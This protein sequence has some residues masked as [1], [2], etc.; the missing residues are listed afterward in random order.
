VR[1]PPGFVGKRKQFVGKRKQ[2]V[3]KGKGKQNQIE[4]NFLIYWN[5]YS[6]GEKICINYHTQSRTGKV[7]Y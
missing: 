7:G 1:D 6:K 5:L 4:F 2:F 3:G